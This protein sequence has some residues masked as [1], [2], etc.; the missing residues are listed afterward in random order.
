MFGKDLEPPDAT[1]IYWRCSPMAVSFPTGL[2]PLLCDRFWSRFSTNGI[3][4]FV[5]RTELTWRHLYSW[6]YNQVEKLR[7]VLSILWVF[8]RNLYE[9]S[10]VMIP[11]GSGNSSTF[12]P[13]GSTQWEMGPDLP[14][15]C[16]VGWLSVKKKKMHHVTCYED[17]DGRCLCAKEE[18]LLAWY[19]DV[20]RLQ[21][22]NIGSPT[23]HHWCLLLQTA[24]Q[25]KLN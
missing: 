22:H 10:L 14:V 6:G 18:M 12:L 20:R 13:T 16:N 3:Y 7:L 15:R 24:G 4:L 8:Y 25:E 11:S 1:Y 5:S 2:Q 17:D 21:R 9:A 19:Q 23:S